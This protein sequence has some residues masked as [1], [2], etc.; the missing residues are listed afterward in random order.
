MRAR[1]LTDERKGKLKREVS[2]VTSCL[3]ECA[4]ISLS[5]QPNLGKQASSRER[6]ARAGKGTYLSPKNG[7][8]GTD[9]TK[10]LALKGMWVQPLAGKGGKGE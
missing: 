5:K 6:R 3:G 4:I 1:D 10:G 8:G 9:L 2:I 7:K